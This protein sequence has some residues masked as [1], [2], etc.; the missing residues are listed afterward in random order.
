MKLLNNKEYSTW[1]GMKQRCSNPKS[2]GYK[3]YGGRGISVCE[4]WL[5]FQNFLDDMGERP[6]N[7][8]LDRIDVNGNYEPGNCRWAT[9]VEQA[10]N[11]RQASN[12]VDIGLEKQGDKW[13]CRIWYQGKNRNIGTY[14]KKADAIKAYVYYKIKIQSGAE[15][16]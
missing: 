5:S 9:W 4:R 1:R 2:H 10:D 13:R 3:Y 7:M 16:V 11:R 8:T 6:E 14:T 15:I 12:C